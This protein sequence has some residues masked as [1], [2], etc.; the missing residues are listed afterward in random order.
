M[1][2]MKKD[3]EFLNRQLPNFCLLIFMTAATVGAFTGGIWAALGIGFSAIAFLAVWR[4]ESRMPQPDYQILFF[5]AVMLAVCAALNFRSWQ[6]DLSWK[7]WLQL[8]SIF[9]PLSLLTAPEIQ[10]RSFSS[11][12]PFWL[13]GAV[14]IAAIALGIEL[15]LHGPL[16][17]LV[18]GNE[19]LFEYNRG[20]SYLVL[21]AFPVMAMLMLTKRKWLIVP[22]IAILLIPA[23]LTESR[24]AKLALV[25]GLATAIAAYYLPRVT[26]RVLAFVPFLS[27]GWP[28][29]AQ[30][31]FLI[32]HDWI[33][34]LPHSWRD[35]VE[36][37]DNM[38]YRIAEHPLL[39][40]GLGTIPKLPVEPQGALY[41]DEISPP[42]PHNALI[43]LWVELGIPGLA[44]GILFALMILHRTGRLKPDIMPYALGAWMAAYCLSMI[45][46]DFWTDSLWAAFALT[47]FA[48]A[49]LDRHLTAKRPKLTSG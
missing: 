3:A 45:S 14:A 1:V 17:K 41:L 18:R 19:F 39:G 37:W 35:R 25:L 8:A 23:S 5:I 13:P 21:L 6:P 15:A 20:F 24:A 22:L 32:H 30:K 16:L 43:Q 38:S 27:I 44:L 10:N 40:W 9:L 33:L 28:F 4:I 36:I 11:R 12:L 42:H 7:K 48:F 29:A 31:I 2:A 49:L 26:R 47:G 46:Y 34:R